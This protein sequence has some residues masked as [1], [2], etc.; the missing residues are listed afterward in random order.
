MIV[1]MYT[2][3]MMTAKNVNLVSSAIMIYELALIFSPFRG[4]RGAIFHINAFERV[5]VLFCLIKKSCMLQMMI[6]FPKT[7]PL[8]PLEKLVSIVS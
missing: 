4:K 6:S 1:H 5:E 3:N 2:D 7:T 8:L